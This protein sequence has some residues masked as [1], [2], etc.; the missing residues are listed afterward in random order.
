MILI[1][2]IL[3]LDETASVRNRFFD[4]SISSFISEKT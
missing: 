2:N 1:F 4:Q 3:S